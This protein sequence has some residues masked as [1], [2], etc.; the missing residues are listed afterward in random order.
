MN[1]ALTLAT[2]LAIFA[3]LFHSVMGERF[4][5]IRLFRRTDLP[6]LYGSED[7]TKRTLRFAWHITSIAWWG[8]GAMLWR[9]GRGTLTT[10]AVA[11]CIAGVF[12]TSALVTL[13]MSRGRHLAWPVFLFIGGTAFWAALG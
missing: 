7:F 9:L 11:G 4:I 12:L 6:K 3:G 8:F 10:Q 2:C 5:L 1:L 13:V